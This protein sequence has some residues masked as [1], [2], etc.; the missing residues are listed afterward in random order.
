MRHKVVK[1]SRSGKEIGEYS[2]AETVRLFRSGEL[3]DTDTYWHEGLKTP[4]L[5]GSLLKKE[6]DT[7]EL[8]KGQWGLDFEGTSA[9]ARLY[10]G[11]SMLW[12]GLLGLIAVSGALRIK[13]KAIDTMIA[14]LI[15]WGIIH[16][17]YFILSPKSSSASADVSVVSFSK[18]VFGY[19]ILFVLVFHLIFKV[20]PY[21]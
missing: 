16:F 12:V 9:S 4:R 14:G 11:V 7:D 20:N 1:I 13:S 15:I 2:I 17:T 21:A 18:K 5:V 3:Q 8:S 6:E 10:Y 19:S